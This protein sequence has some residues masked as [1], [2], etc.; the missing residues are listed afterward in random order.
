[1]Q[2]ESPSISPKEIDRAQSSPSLALGTNKHLYKR[3]EKGNG[4]SRNEDLFYTVNRVV[5]GPTVTSQSQE[6]LLKETR[7]RCFEAQKADILDKVKKW[8]DR[9]AGSAAKE[10][11]ESGRLPERVPT[12]SLIESFFEE[13][14]QK[15]SCA[16]MDTSAQV[17]IWQRRLK[18]KVIDQMQDDNIQDIEN[19]LGPIYKNAELEKYQVGLKCVDFPPAESL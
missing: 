17:Q 12:A 1:M 6:K 13:P 16:T 14:K 19:P 11:K 9:A 2:E 7:A 3:D 18:E 5:K 15:T 4:V 8:H 10:G